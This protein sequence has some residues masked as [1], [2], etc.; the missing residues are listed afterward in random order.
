MD[1]FIWCLLLCG[2]TGAGVILYSIK[3]FHGEKN[4]EA[5]APSDD[6]MSIDRKIS[7]FGSSIQDAD[8]VYENLDTLSKDVFKEFDTKY[9]ELLFLY[10]LIDD[11]KKEL[12]DIDTVKPEE[13]EPVAHIPKE[14]G[15]RETEPEAAQKKET[16]IMPSNPR[17]EQ[18]MRMKDEGLTAAEIAKKLKMG[19]GEVMLL[20]NL[21][22]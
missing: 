21:S 17:F 5:S 19:K 13:R 14:A 2:V 8:N 3:N 16:R 1:F 10:T 22:R 4:E 18:I 15:V 7:R 20:F 6:D 9:Q 12:S 11:K